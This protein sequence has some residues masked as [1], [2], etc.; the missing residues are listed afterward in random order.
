MKK[1]ALIGS[2]WALPLLAFAQVRNITDAANLITGIINNV[3]VPLIF[4][5]A[6][7]VFIWG[8]F[9]YFIASG[10]NDEK[11]E[12]GKKLMLYGIVGFFLMVSVWGLVNILLGTVQLSNSAP[13]LPQAPAAR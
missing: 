3:L 12:N 7:V 8:V 10:D 11:R 9:T 1:F 2:A 4:A 6:F 5:V 13:N